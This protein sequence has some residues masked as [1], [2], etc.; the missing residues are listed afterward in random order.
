VTESLEG[1]TP[2]LRLLEDAAS[3]LKDPQ[4]AMDLGR[5]GINTSVALIA[6]QGIIAYLRGDKDQSVEDLST[7]VE[8]IR[9]RRERG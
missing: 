7:A 5:R 6:V 9:A 8:E 3:L 1:R 4:F 2:I